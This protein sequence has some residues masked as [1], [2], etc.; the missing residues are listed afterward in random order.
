MY[1]AQLHLRQD[2][3]CVLSRLAARVDGPLEVTMEELHDSK[4]TFVLHAGAHADDFERVLGEEE[5]VTNVDRLDADTIGATKRSC[6]AYDAIYG[7][8]GVLR[9][10]SRI[11]SD[12]RVYNILFFDKTDLRSMVT[13]FRDIGD[14]RIERLT[15]VGSPDPK[16][17]DRQREVVE[18]ALREGYFEWPR[19]IDSE[20]LADRLGITRATCLEHLRK[21]EETLLRDALDLEKEKAQSEQSSFVPP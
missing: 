14:V 18:A 15:R 6:G 1:E 4:I 11:S 21:A 7:N 19:R 5:A 8:H 10:D 3:E 16:L 2:K 13:E 17:T 9:R 20:E 12:E